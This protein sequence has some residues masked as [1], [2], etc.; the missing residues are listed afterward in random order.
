MSECAKVLEIA[1]AEVGYLE[2]KS[3]S[4]LDDKTANAGKNNFTKYA[5]DLDKISG[6]YNGKKNGYAWCDVFVDW[7][8]VQ[9]VGVE[10]AKAL[11]GQPN[12]SLGAGCQYSAKYYSNK[13]MYFL[14]PKVGDQ[15]FF[16]DSSGSICHTGLVYK[17]DS[18][19]VYTIEGNTSSAAG[20]VTNGGSVAKKKYKLNYNMIAGYGRPDYAEEER[21]E[22]EVAKTYKNG[23]TSEPVYADTSLKTKTGSLDPRETCECLAIVNG[24]Y[25]VKYKVNGTSNYK[26]GFVKYNGGVK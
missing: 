13:M 20:V 26:C 16:R 4:K 21:E 7:C 8:F 15:I 3:N 22:F 12:N 25:L 9:A 5:R 10:R 19:Y 6:F 18:T 1:A 2:K 14:Y 11:L 24:R 17:V 23:S